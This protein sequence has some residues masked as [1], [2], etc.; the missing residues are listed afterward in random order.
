MPGRRVCPM[1][2]G[3]VVGRDER[4]SDDDQRARIGP[5]GRTDLLLQGHDREEAEDP[6]R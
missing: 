2:E 5:G 3:P 4:L 1:Q 6:R